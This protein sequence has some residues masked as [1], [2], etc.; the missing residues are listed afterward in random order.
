MALDQSLFLEVYRQGGERRRTKLNSL[1]STAYIDDR[2][3]RR[4]LLPTSSHFEAPNEQ[5]AANYHGIGR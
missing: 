1:E 3:R 2:I 4:L 5:T